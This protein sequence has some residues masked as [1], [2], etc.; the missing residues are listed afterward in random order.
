V[1]TSAD[2]SRSSVSPSF[3][4]GLAGIQLRRGIHPDGDYLC[5]LEA[6]ALFAPLETA[7]PVAASAIVRLNDGI[8]DD[9]RRTD[10]LLP[11]LPRLIGSRLQAR[12]AQR[13]S[14]LAADWSLRRLAP[15]ELEALG[16]HRQAD[17]LRALPPVVDEPSATA[18]L[19]TATVLA[20]SAS[21]DLEYSLDTAARGCEVRTVQGL[22]GPVHQLERVLD[23]ATFLALEPEF[24]VRAA[25]SAEKPLFPLD[26]PTAAALGIELV[27][28]LLAIPA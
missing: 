19:R 20:P 27:E 2:A 6:F 21:A 11:L 23:L 28:A 3:L 5:A 22:R 14:W 4:P 25:E 18:A 26:E 1:F 16:H 12:G 24:R 9:R 7:C 13:R 8:W 10:L 17:H 15:I